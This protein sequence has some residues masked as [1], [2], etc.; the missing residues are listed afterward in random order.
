MIAI[1][2]LSGTL[3]YNIQKLKI[4]K[5]TSEH[6]FYYGR[7]VFTIT[8]KLCSICKLLFKG[9]LPDQLIQSMF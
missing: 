6:L 8:V 5:I 7:P 4:L 2:K 3:K 1:A 9:T